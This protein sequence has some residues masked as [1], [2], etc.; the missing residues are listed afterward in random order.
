MSTQSEDVKTSAEFEQ[1]PKQILQQVR[2]T[3]RPIV[4]TVQGKPGV[5]VMKAADYQRQLQAAN[6]SQLLLQGESD[7]QAGRTRPAADVLKD[8]RRGKKI[9]R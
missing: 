2:K 7:V 5:V 9:S 1:R 8:L 4:V 6:L 3:G